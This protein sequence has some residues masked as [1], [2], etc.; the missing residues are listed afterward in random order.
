MT[1][2]NH[3]VF[4]PGDRLDLETADEFRR[5]ADRFLTST[6]SHAIVDLGATAEMDVPGFAALAYLLI[7][8]RASR[9][10]VALAG[11]ISAPVRRLIDFSGFETLFEAA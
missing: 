3:I 8:S 7:R 11:P 5:E 1:V 9:R 2:P 6:A 10:S 4:R